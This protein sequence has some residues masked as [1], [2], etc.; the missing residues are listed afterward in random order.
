M[1]KYSRTSQ[2]VMSSCHRFETNTFNEADVRSIIIEQREISGYLIREVGDLIA[3]PSR[4][5]GFSYDKV[6]QIFSSIQFFNTYNDNGT[7]KSPSMYGKCD[8]WL[9]GYLLKQL[10]LSNQKRIVKKLGISV[11]EIRRNLKSLF[12]EENFPTEVTRPISMK[13]MAIISEIC[14]HLYT[15]NIFKIENIRNEIR[16]MLKAI[17]LPI[18]KNYIDDFIV[19]ICIILNGTVFKLKR[20]SVGDA[21]IHIEKNESSGN[22]PHGFFSV[23]V[24][25]DTPSGGNNVRWSIPILTTDIATNGYLDNSMIEIDSFGVQRFDFSRQFDF[26]KSRDRPIAAAALT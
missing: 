6:F 7:I 11:R 20:E 25:A 5:R 22:S 16:K 3:H 15:H 9:K 12:P 23:Y 1:K 18:G 17:G 24:A 4:D 19:C 14:S 21:S 10:E 8:W 2:S 26:V 13:D